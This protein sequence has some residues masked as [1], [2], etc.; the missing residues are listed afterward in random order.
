MYINL[1]FYEQSRVV[2]CAEGER[3]YHIF[4]QLCVGA[5]PALRGCLPLV[6]DVSYDTF[7]LPNDFLECK[8]SPFEYFHSNDDLP[9]SIVAYL[10]CLHGWNLK[11][12]RVITTAI[13][14]L[15]V[16]VCINISE[17]I[18]M[19][20]VN[21]IVT[22]CF[23][24]MNHAY[25]QCFLKM[26]HVVSILIVLHLFFPLIMDSGIHKLGSSI[27]LLVK[28]ILETGDFC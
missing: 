2:Q 21:F 12:S 22:G 11:S 4:Y 6:F 3:A 8:H 25:E 19:V 17:S 18:Y 15:N 24:K 26:N 28:V 9:V 23:L 5:P 10:N 1:L 13:P 16:L 7:L 20:M 27:K 14:L